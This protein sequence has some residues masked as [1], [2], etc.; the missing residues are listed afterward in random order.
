MAVW[1]LGLEA[2]L[3][4]GAGRVTEASIAQN[5]ATRVSEYMRYSIYISAAGV[6]HGT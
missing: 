3:P 4:V 2:N 5:C 6:N 1:A